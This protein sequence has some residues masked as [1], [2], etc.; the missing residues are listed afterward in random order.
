M[1]KALSNTFILF[2]FL[3]SYSQDLGNLGSSSGIFKPLK[4]APD[5]NL[6][7]R[8][9]KLKPQKPTV[10]TKK[11]VTKKVV[12]NSKTIPQEIETPSDVILKDYENLIVRANLARDERNY[13]A[14]E[15]LYYQATLLNPKDFR[16]FYGL[17]NVFA[18]QQRWE[19]AEK[20]YKK[21]LEIN[22]ENPE[23]LIALSFV[24]TQPIIGVN[25]SERYL[26]A[27][28][29]ALKAM[30]VSPSSAMAYNLLGLSLELQ[31]KFNQDVETYYRKA[32]ELAPHFAITYAHLA[33]FLNRKGNT[34]EAKK[35]YAKAIQLAKD[36]PM[37]ILVAE[38]LQSDQKFFE[39]E[40]L[41]KQALLVDPRNPYALFLLGRALI[42]KGEFKEAE[43]LLKNS[44]RL[45]PNNFVTHLELASLYMRQRNYILAEKALEDA[46][47]ITH[48]NEKRRVALEFEVLADR[49]KK[50]GNT[51]E[52]LRI[53]KK[54]LAILPKEKRLLVKISKIK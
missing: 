42:V 10:Q 8:N 52:A 2:L 31:G 34:E 25:L 23:A 35:L 33:R 14:A 48:K 46:L 49:L 40:Q 41:L 43:D 19:E 9:P 15:D 21:A 20:L 18:D 38:V 16:A 39:S 37:M 5:K 12:T 24:L 1:K 26:L 45:N 44:M 51:Q 30:Q 54:S 47:N 4:P 32:I 3:S 13:K 7:S 6:S 36:T 22:P 27:E 50:E 53:Y 17:G 11:S 28:K 29:L